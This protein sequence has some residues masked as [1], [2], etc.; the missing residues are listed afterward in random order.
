MRLT[1]FRTASAPAAI[2]SVKRLYNSIRA[3]FEISPFSTAI[4]NFD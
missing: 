3:S 1:I 2:L 4:N